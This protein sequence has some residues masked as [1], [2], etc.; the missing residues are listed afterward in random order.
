[1]E[2]KIDGSGNPYVDVGNSRITLVPE[3]WAGQ[4]GV[5]IQAYKEAGGLNPGPEIPLPAKRDAYDLIEGLVRIL[6]RIPYRYYF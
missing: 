2:E 3:T 4:P 6:L 1:M 5:R